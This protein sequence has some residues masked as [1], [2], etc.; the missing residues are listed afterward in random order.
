MPGGGSGPG[1]GRSSSPPRC[2]MTSP[3]RSAP[4][5]TWGGSRRGATLRRG[6]RMARLALWNND[7]A[8]SSRRPR[9][10][11]ARPSSGWSGITGCPS[12]GPARPTASRRLVEASYQCRLD[13][14]ALLA[15]ADVR[16]RDCADRAGLLDRVVLFRELADEEGCLDRPRS[17]ASGHTRF[18]YFQGRDLC[19]DDPAYDDT[20]GTVIVMSG[21]PGAGKDTWIGRNVPERPV[22]ALDEIRRELGVDPQD[23]Q[24][25]VANA[26]RDRARVWL[27]AG[28]ALRLERDQH[29]ATPSRLPDPSVRLLSRTG[30]DRLHRGTVGRP[31]AQE[32]GTP[33]SRPLARRRIHGRQARGPLPRRGPR[34]RLVRSRRSGR[35]LTEVRAWLGV[36]PCWRRPRFGVRRRP[37]PGRLGIT[38]SWEG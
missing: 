18:L 22:I 23:D 35:T 7:E 34:R 12:P 5:R 25:T 32:P 6:A 19:P 20:R 21:L 10:R 37:L 31:R 15:E 26:A 24:G 3:S 2:S 30:R 13:W 36:A 14:L 9:Y 8:G 16:G 27:R 4:A 29:H 28:D 38:W 33:A 11:S 17:F 1:N